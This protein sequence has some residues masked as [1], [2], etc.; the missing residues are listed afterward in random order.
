MTL[1][2]ECS[3]RI[4]RGIRLL[5]GLDYDGAVA[6][7]L[8]R[9]LASRHL[10]YDAAARSDGGIA[11]AAR[12][13]RRHDALR[14]VLEH[15]GWP[16]A[17]GKDA[18]QAWRREVEQFAQLPNTFCKLSGLGM[19]LHST[20][21]NVFSDYFRACIDLFGVSRCMFASNFP[22]DLSY[23]T[24][25][26]LFSVFEHVASHYSEAEAT[27]LFERTAERVCGI[28]EGLG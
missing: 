28:P 2:R 6:E 15:T 25:A 7:A 16:V 20:Q 5:G 9:A 18:F 10:V 1:D 22:V 17:A 14:V 21:L 11:A 19:V 24:A 12:G 13:L 4:Y 23:G 8:L 26:E 3:Y 27:M